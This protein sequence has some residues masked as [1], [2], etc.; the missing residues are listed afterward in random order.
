MKT[1]EYMAGILTIQI[2]LKSIPGMIKYLW[3]GREWIQG[4]K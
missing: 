3:I 1:L 2:N 4:V